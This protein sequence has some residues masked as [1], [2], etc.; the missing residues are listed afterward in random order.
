MKNNK[1]TIIMIFLFFIGLFLLLYPSVS[2]Y[3][4]QKVGSRAIVDYESILNNMDK[5]KYTEI[6]NDANEYNQKISKLQ[7]PFV[8]YETVKGYNDQLNVSDNGMIGYIKIS[9]IKVELPIYHGTSKA[10][11]STAVGHLEGSSL[12]IGGVGTHSVLSAHRGLPT[13]KLFTD[14]DKIEIGDTFTITILNR[15]MTYEVDQIEIVEPSDIKK[16]KIDP[17]QDY[18]TLMTCTPYGINSHRMLVRG[19]RIEN[20]K[21]KTYVTTEAFR[22]STLVVTP[23][24]AIPIVLIILI[25]IVLKPVENNFNKVKEMYIYPSKFKVGGIKNGKK[26]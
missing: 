14:L 3:Y 17:N 7:N 25:I 8:S 5:D 13:S 26:I 11:L 4:N 22:I 16:L 1:V 12:P 20:I 21:E 2:N 9:K 24:V 15:L 6:F 10:V 19:K 23:M 18:V